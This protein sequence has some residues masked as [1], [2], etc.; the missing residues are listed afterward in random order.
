[1]YPTLPI[2]NFPRQENNLSPEPIRVILQME[3]NYPN[4]RPGFQAGP[5]QAKA[6][7]EPLPPTQDKIKIIAG[8]FIV[9]LGLLLLAG[10]FGMLAGHAVNLL[11]VDTQAL[12]TI[13]ICGLS[14]TFG[15]LS[16]QSPDAKGS[17]TLAH[18]DLPLSFK[19]EQR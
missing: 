12:Q 16:L 3:G 10:A 9:A 19:F 8:Y 2:N 15:G 17:F 13:F 6:Q 14:A 1:M 5:G 11:T 18:A 4:L 7:A